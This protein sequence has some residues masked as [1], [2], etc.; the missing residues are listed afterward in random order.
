MK[1]I[2]KRESSKDAIVEYQF[3]IDGNESNQICV[4][5]H[6]VIRLKLY[7]MIKNGTVDNISY[8]N[9]GVGFT[10]DGIAEVLGVDYCNYKVVIGVDRRYLQNEKYIEYLISFLLREQYFTSGKIDLL[11]GIYTY[12]TGRKVSGG[13]YAGNL[14]V[15][16]DGKVQK[17]YDEQFANEVYENS[18]PQIERNQN[19]E[20]FDKQ[21]AELQKAY[22][23]EFQIF[24]RKLQARYAEDVKKLA[25]E[26]NMLGQSVYIENLDFFVGISSEQEF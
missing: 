3:R 22:A 19:K 12:G 2:S 25:K 6:N 24:K 10:K 5:P 14:E 9:A 13:N 11:N 17:T 4:W 21:K 1:L 23:Q 8:Y 7:S 20:Q 18:R 16:E 26:C 15:D